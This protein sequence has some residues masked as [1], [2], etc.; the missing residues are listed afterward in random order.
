VS[1]LLTIVSIAIAGCG[2][3]DRRPP[4]P[5]L[6]IATGG[7]GGVFYPLA[8]ALAQAYTDQ[9]PSLA[10]H[11]VIGGSSA[12]VE[13]VRKGTAQIGF[14]QADIA[15]IAYSRGPH[16]GAPPYTDLRAVALLWSN[17]AQLVVP[18]NSSIKSVGDLRGRRVAVGTVGSGTE[19]LARIILTAYGL[20]YHDIQPAFLSFRETIA[21]VR[22]GE[23]DAAFAVAGIPTPAV[24]ELNQ[25]P[26]VRLVP[27]DSDRIN[28][29]R[30]E[31]P[32]LRPIVLARGTY[33]GQEVDVPAV[34]VDDVLICRSDLD[35]DYVYLLTKWFFDALPRLARDNPAAREIDIDRAPAT[36][37]P[38]HPGAARYYRER[39]I[40]R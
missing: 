15:Y 19:G 33:K 7:P 18:R 1:A 34:G 2:R 6:T 8:S 29:M 12:T 35:A 24:L 26:G 32:F 21:Q 36:P 37:I 27:I 13:A 38:L 20:T 14:T 31:Y 4:V 10:T 11:L 16:P 22:N 9:L 17:T 23:I 28:A 39:E 40:G 30:A 25:R 3:G 5:R